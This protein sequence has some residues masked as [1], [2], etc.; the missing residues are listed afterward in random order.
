MAKLFEVQNYNSA[1]VATG[2]IRRVRVAVHDTDTGKL[3][4]CVLNIAGELD[5]EDLVGKWRFLASIDECK[6]LRAQGPR[7]VV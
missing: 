6:C 4:V 3:A 5:A 7:G 1:I 2:E